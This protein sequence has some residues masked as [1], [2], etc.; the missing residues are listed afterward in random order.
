MQAMPRGI[1]VRLTIEA[2][3]FFVI[4]NYITEPTW[5]SIGSLGFL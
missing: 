2:I 4:L 1:R 3:F 5:I